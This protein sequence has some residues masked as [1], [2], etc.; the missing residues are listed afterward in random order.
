M[1]QLR[2]N[3]CRPEGR[4]KERKKNRKERREKKGGP[5]E[6]RNGKEGK[7]NVQ[8]IFPEDNYNSKIYPIAYKK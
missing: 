1:K 2:G 6:R 4:K 5:S 8:Q 3:P 7:K